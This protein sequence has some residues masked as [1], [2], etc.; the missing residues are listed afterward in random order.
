MRTENDLIGLRAYALSWLIV[1][2]AAVAAG[3][4][5]AAVVRLAGWV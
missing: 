5:I 3:I 4:I 2:G 1:G